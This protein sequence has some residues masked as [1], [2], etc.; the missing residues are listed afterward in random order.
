L[1]DLTGKVNHYQLAE[2]NENNSQF[3]IS[4]ADLPAGIYY[5]RVSNALTTT[6][7]KVVKH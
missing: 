6:I 1:V 3:D 4:V 2:V 7:Q 5:V